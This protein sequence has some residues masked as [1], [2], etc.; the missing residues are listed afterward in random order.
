MACQLR[1]L[2]ECLAPPQQAQ[3]VSRT[4]WYIRE[5]P[6]Q[7]WFKLS[8][9]WL[10]VPIRPRP[11]ARARKIKAFDF[12]FDPEQQRSKIAWEEILVSNLVMLDLSPTI[13]HCTYD[14]QTQRRKDSRQE[15]NQ[16]LWWWSQQLTALQAVGG[17]VDLGVVD[18]VLRVVSLLLGD[19]E[20]PVA[21]PGSGRGVVNHALRVPPVDCLFALANV[22][23]NGVLCCQRNK[24]KVPW[25]KIG[26][27]SSLYFHFL[28]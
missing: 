17:A 11:C 27:K 21:E 6:R 15:K 12:E 26:F 25:K 3:A 10:I 5:L 22:P 14:H 20:N 9:T 18:G 28:W 24:T 4:F 16:G 7:L 13:V 2:W 19:H 1:V 23:A 8:V